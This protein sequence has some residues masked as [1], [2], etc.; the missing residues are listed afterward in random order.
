MSMHLRTRR[1][2]WT[3]VA[4]GAAAL[5]FTIG[6]ALSHAAAQ[7]PPAGQGAG[8]DPALRE[9]L[10]ANGLL[11][12]GMNELAVGEYRR[13]LEAHPNHEK[14]GVARYGLGVALFRMKKYE[15]AA[16]ELRPL[17]E[18]SDFEFAAETLL[19]VGQ[20]EFEQKKY[21]PAV[22]PLSRLARQHPTHEA[23]DDAAAMAVESLYRLQRYDDIDGV[24]TLFDKNWA[25]SPL[26][27]RADYL[28]GL[29]LVAKKDDAGAAKHLAAMTQRLPQ[30]QFAD[31]ATLLRAQCLHREG[32]LPSAATAYGALLN[33]DDALAADATF[34]LA[35]LSQQAGDD[36]SASEH[37]DRFLEKWP[38]H[39]SIAAAMLDR[40]RLCVAQKQYGR[41]RDLLSKGAEK[42]PQRGDEAAYWL[43]KCDL[44]EE[45]YPQA[46]A[47]LQTAIA[48]NPKSRLLAEMMYDRGVALAKADDIAGAIAAL[49]QFRSAFAD[50]ALEADATALQAT[51]E[52]QRQSY[53]ASAKLCEAFLSRHGDHA[54]ASAIA[55]LAA[56]DDMLRDQFDD[57]AAKYETFLAKYPDDAQARTARY[58]LGSAQFRLDRADDAQKNLSQVV[59][60]RETEKPYRRALLMLGDIAFQKSE[61][62]QAIGL[63]GDYL[64]FGSE[65][66]SADDA[67]LKLGLALARSER[68]DDAAAKFSHLL[69]N[70]PESP[71]R[72]QAIFERGQVLL[73][74]DKLD[75]AAGAFDEVVKA[76][77]SRFHTFALNHLATIAMRKQDWDR[78]AELYA[79]VQ[80]AKPEQGSE[81][82][83]ADAMFRRGQALM[84]AKKYPEAA[85]AFAALLE[86][87]G[88]GDRAAEAQAQRAIALSRS[89]EHEA[90][91][92]SIDALAKLDTSKVAADLLAAVAYEKA[93]CLRELKRP[94]DAMQAYRDLLTAHDDDVNAPHAML[95]LA[96]MEAAAGNHE[97]AAQLLGRLN[98]V[99]DTEARKIDPG[100][101]ERGLYRL[102]VSEFELK[103]NEEAARHAEAFI[104]AFAES[105]LIP[106][107][108]LFAGEAQFK[109]SQWQEAGGHF[110]TIAKTFR[111]DDGVPTALLRLGECE[112]QLQRWP[113]SEKAFT[114]YLERF[115]DS[116]LWFQAQFGLAYARENRG[117]H[118]QAMEAYRK[119]IDRHS[120]PTAARAQFQIGE[121]LFAQKK[122]SD[123]VREL[124]K[125]DILYGYPEW[126]AA[127]LFEAGRCFEEMGQ[128]EQ[129][130]AQ[131]A[132]VKEKYPDTEWAKLASQRLAANV[133]STGGG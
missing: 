68:L 12:R 87:G 69:S 86:Q 80:G 84:A 58:R 107:A 121:C 36:K 113:E 17:L 76:G 22:E 1:K 117:L 75:D 125:V 72:L 11:N 109:L 30:G 99:A 105:S 119:V 33:K 44:R 53:D 131:F 2:T 103:K 93:W 24:W 132:Q 26:R 45:K 38:E 81:D 28:R 108:H 96:E 67:T 4:A 56:E 41:A 116:E 91:L 120:G 83:T 21:E 90:A 27:E 32:D 40:G 88:G 89:G 123:A 35:V 5:A 59:N 31:R 39:P 65:Q 104:T 18:K 49:D 62:E 46:A 111:D 14:A 100:V 25:E 19:I 63:L 13:F 48:A 124:L 34:G 29:A 47:R 16:T 114:D 71:H 110:S 78:A 98:E 73:A 106:S 50:H 23:A 129:A 37:F 55:F 52:H 3:A 112:A 130:R 85:S 64:S 20:S 66:P 92:A 97:Q 42:D 128:S 82:M 118:D 43:A 122:H 51:L 9:Y 77:D 7:Q 133:S 74:Q 102:A 54:Q 115:S 101:R 61:W 15:E 6:P 60:G 126:S 70:F 95:E 10:S 8:S 94:D 127:A 79:Q 57:A